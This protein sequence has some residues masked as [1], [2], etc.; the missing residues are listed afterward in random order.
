MKTSGD[1]RAIQVASLVLAA[2]FSVSEFTG[3]AFADSLPTLSDPVVNTFG[4]TYAQFIDSYFYAAKTGDTAR[5]AG[6]QAKESE[7]QQQLAQ[8]T[9]PN[10][11]VKQDEDEKSQNFLAASKQK[12]T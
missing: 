3:R 4:K 9:Q 5:L 6:I 11:K 2:A 8:L 7:L 12:N 1:M 10:G